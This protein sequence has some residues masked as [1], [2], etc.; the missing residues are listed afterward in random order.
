[1]GL[2]LHLVCE[3]DLRNKYASHEIGGWTSTSASKEINI[4]SWR[5]HIKETTLY[6]S[7]YNKKALIIID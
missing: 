2:E 5:F 4:W 3:F 7:K 6:V 1:M